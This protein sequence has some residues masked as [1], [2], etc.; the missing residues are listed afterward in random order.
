MHF[1]ADS[2]RLRQPEAL[3]K[4][5]SAPVFAEGDDLCYYNSL[6]FGKYDEM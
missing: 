3:A 2:G 6:S 5:E 1:I 4:K